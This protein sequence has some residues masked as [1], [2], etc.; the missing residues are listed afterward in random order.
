M[1]RKPH[2]LVF[3]TE[4]GGTDVDNDPILQCFVM[5]TDARG[6]EIASREWFIYDPE[7]PGSPEAAEVHGFTTEFLAENGIDPVAALEDIRGWLLDHRDLTWIAYNASFDLSILNA[8]FKRYGVTDKFGDFVENMATL[9]DPIILSR[10]HDKYKKGGHRLETVAKR[11]GIEFDPDEAHSAV[12]DVK[13]TAEVAVKLAEKYGIPSKE[14]QKTMFR[15]WAVDTT[16]FFD[17]VGKV[18]EVTGEK[19]VLNPNWPLQNTV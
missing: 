18:D 17:K 4:T 3:D 16:A 12:Y 19:I 13:K 14:E 1:S 6:E 5:I 9:Y 2:Y 10:T 15:T 7:R 8:E 11:Y